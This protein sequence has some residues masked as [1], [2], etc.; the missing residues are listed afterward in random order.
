MHESVLAHVAASLPQKE[1]LATAALAYILNRSEPAR[2]AFGAVIESAVGSVAR[3]LSVRTEQPTDD[4][5]RPDVLLVGEAGSRVGFVEVKFWAGLTDAQPV[6]YLKALALTPSSV[7]VVLAPARRLPALK[8][9]FQQRCRSAGLMLAVRSEVAMECSGTRIALLSWTQVLD[10]LTRA[11]IDDR[12]SAAD[13]DQ[14]RGLCEQMEAEGFFALTREEIDDLATPKRYLMLAGLVDEAVERAVADGIVSVKRLKVTPRKGGYGRYVLLPRAGCWVG[15][16][17]ELWAQHGQSPL[18]IDFGAD[19]WGQAVGVATA[20]RAWLLAS[21]P[22]AYRSD[23]DGR[24]EIPV[25]LL[26]NSTRE[27]VIASFLALIRELDAAMV[28][29]GMKPPGGAASL[30]E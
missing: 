29:A 11:T 2:R 24:V 23:D 13:V 30:P 14:L 21:P 18:W 16:D 12:L 28:A 9:E 15:I 26:S 22:R 17:H 10:Q 27:E 6:A 8:N 1:N 7:L 5:N 19:D 4:A 3:I 25:P 20:L